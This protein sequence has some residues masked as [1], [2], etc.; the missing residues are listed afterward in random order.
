MATQ[1]QCPSLDYDYGAVDVTLLP[2]RGDARFTV[3]RHLLYAAR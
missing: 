2:A 3:N 1:K